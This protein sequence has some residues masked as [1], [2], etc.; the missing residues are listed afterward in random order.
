M[1]N[2]WHIIYL[3]EDSKEKIELKN[4]VESILAVHAQKLF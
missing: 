3:K 2:Y 4:D 1:E